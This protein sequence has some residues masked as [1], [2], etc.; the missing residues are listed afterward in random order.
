MGL[1]QVDVGSLGLLC[2]DILDQLV[3]VLEP[4]HGRVVLEVGPHSHHDML[5]GIMLSLCKVIKEPFKTCKDCSI[6]G[7][8]AL[9]SGDSSLNPRLGPK[10]IILIIQLKKKNLKFR[11]TALKGLTS[12]FQIDSC[13]IS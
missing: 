7:T 10:G 12:P 8:L 1:Y 6:G 2:V 9:G 4:D 5:S 3:H 11:I 13:L